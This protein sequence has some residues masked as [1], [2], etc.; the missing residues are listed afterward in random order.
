MTR[1]NDRG[2]RRRVDR[3]FF[4][5]ATV[6]MM[7]LSG[8]NSEDGDEE[9]NNDGERE[10]TTT[11]GGLLGGE[12]TTAG[13]ADTAGSNDS[14][15]EPESANV[16]QCS[17]LSGSFTRFDPGAKPLPFTFEYPSA[18]SDTM[19]FAYPDELET[20]P[21]VRARLERGSDA[22]GDGDIRLSADIAYEQ[23]SEDGRDDWYES[24][25]GEVFATTQIN[26]QA[27]DFIYNPDGPRGDDN[28]VYSINGMFPYAGST[29]T[30]YHLTTLNVAVRLVRADADSVTDACSQTLRDTLRRMADSMRLNDATTFEEYF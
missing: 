11:D 12:R 6:G 27:V 22:N 14:T 26:G 9:E 21:G 29:G 15:P 25:E 24:A 17:I 1:A 13:T 20:T 19:G 28:N 8:C 3:R 7:G 18:M 10:D 2:S 30:T 5:A 16:R 23:R 4:L